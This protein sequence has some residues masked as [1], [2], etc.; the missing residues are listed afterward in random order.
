MLGI[1]AGTLKKA[2]HAGA[3]VRAHNWNEAKRILSAVGAA[4]DLPSARVDMKSF[5]RGHQAAS[6][7]VM[8]NAVRRLLK[9]FD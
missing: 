8:I 3:A 6:A 4:L 9:E 1:Q 2:R 5:E 7:S